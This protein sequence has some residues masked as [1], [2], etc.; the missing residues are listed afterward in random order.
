MIL[1]GR[2]ETPAVMVPSLAMSL[3]CCILRALRLLMAPFN[4]T[5]NRTARYRCG[6]QDTGVES[7]IRV[8]R[9][10]GMYRIA[11]FKIWP[12]PDSTGY[13]TNCPAGTGYLDTCCII[14]I[15]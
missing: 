15:F 6:G 3:L 8:W 9:E 14:V 10:I 7:E 2:C 4:M 12:K 11:I 13:L 1:L 5:R